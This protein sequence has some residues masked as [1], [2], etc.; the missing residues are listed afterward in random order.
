[1]RRNRQLGFAP[2]VIEHVGR[3]LI[4]P[5]RQLAIGRAHATVGSL[6][7]VEGD[8]HLDPQLSAL[9]TTLMRPAALPFPAR[10]A[11]DAVPDD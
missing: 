10:D 5:A 3:H 9:V 4:E 11:G 1:M 6:H 7:L 2:P 8:N